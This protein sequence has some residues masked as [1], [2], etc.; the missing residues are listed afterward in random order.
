MGIVT[1][2]C[3]RLGDFAAAMQTANEVDCRAYRAIG[4]HE[5]ADEH[6]DKANAWCARKNRL[7]AKASA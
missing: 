5:S 4:D 6:G 2:T 3:A 1:W 7:R